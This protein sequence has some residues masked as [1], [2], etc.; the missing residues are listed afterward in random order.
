MSLVYVAPLDC[1][2]MILPE[3]IYPL[4]GEIRLYDKNNK[5]SLIGNAHVDR[6]NELINCKCL[7]A[8]IDYPESEEVEMIIGGQKKKVRKITVKAEDIPLDYRYEFDVVD[9]DENIIITINGTGSIGCDLAITMD[10]D[11]K[12]KCNLMFKPINKYT[13]KQP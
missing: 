7:I 3:E 4:D 5:L 8:N 11:K 2:G 10:Y 1:I 6:G 9:N 12:T 13:I